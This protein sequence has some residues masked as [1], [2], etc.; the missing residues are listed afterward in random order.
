MQDVGIID[1]NTFSD[2]VEVDLGMLHML[3]LNGVGG[4]VHSADVITVDK[5]C[6]LTTE[7]EALGGATGANK[8]QPRR[9]NQHRRSI[10]RRC[11]GA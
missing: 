4:K 6:S 10:R 7:H 5:K 9:D 2:E 1:G 3:V 8:L 11:S